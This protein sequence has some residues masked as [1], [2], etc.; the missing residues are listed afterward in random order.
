MIVVHNQIGFMAEQ[1]LKPDTVSII[2]H[3]LEPQYN[4]SIGRAADWPDEYCHTDEGHFS[5]QWHYFNTY[6]HPPSACNFNYT[7]DKCSKGGCVISAIANQTN[8]LKKCV[9][10]VK[11]G[12]LS[13]GTNLT[14]SY[15]LK[16]VSHFLGDITQPLHASGRDVGGN[17]YWVIFDNVTARLHSVGHRLWAM[18][19]YS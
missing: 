19:I 2:A 16:W 1:F 12:S 5:C 15:A 11:S 7:E 6:D 14:C 8:I 9:A 10:D 18:L 13:G 17:G 4:G 3:I